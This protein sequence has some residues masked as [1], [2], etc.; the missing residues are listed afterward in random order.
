MPLVGHV[1]IFEFDAVAAS[2]G[3]LEPDAGLH[4]I[5]P[6]AFEWLDSEARR[7]TEREGCV[8]LR[9][10]FRNGVRAVQVTSQVGVIR[11]PGGFQIEVLPKI[12][13]AIEGG[14]VGARRFLIEMLCSL[15]FFRHIRTHQAALKAARMPLLEI[16]VSEFLD[17]VEHVIQRGLRGDY[18]VRSGNL[19]ALRGKLS[20][21]EQIR[22]N[23]T[24]RDRFFVE[25]D[26]FSADRPE[27]RL[28]HASLL[29]TLSLTSVQEHQK[30]ARELGFA[31]SE[32]PA[33]SRPSLD[34]ARVRRDRG[35]EHYQSALA[36]ARLILH[37]Q[38]PLTGSGE[39]HA[40]SLLFPMEALF[41]SFVAEQLRK[42]IRSPFVLK[43]QVRAEHLVRHSG[44][45]WFTLKPDLLIVKDGRNRMVLDTKW[46]LLDA[47]KSNG[48]DKYGLS[49]ADFY[50]LLA[51]GTSYLGVDGEMILLYPKTERFQF[52]LPL[53]EF[54]AL[55]RLRLRVVPFC[56]KTK[57]IISHE[58]MDLDE[59]G[60]GIF[61]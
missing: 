51:Y 7:Q 49:Q 47:G 11:T 3:A 56:L 39:H 20:V 33:S 30:R 12:G 43:T 44:K 17:A 41:E 1:S 4:G 42:R 38:S 54:S 40:P 36:W 18:S 46:K 6:P 16:F 31:L 2:N 48:T 59:L 37:E 14:E 61:F 15:P 22:Q 25:Y 9:P 58:A 55:P 35:M 57:R 21:V 19:G 5:P 53:F 50:Q 60:G 29:K 45:D 24:R 10:I 13:K 52:P 26:E 23:M 28:L 34:F 8:W 32:I 27:N